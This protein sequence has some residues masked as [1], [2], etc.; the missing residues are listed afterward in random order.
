VCI[1]S[2]GKRKINPP[3]PQ[4][5]IQRHSACVNHPNADQNDVTHKKGLANFIS[6]LQNPFYL[7]NHIYLLTLTPSGIFAVMLS[8]SQIK[9][10]LATDPALESLRRAGLLQLIGSAH[11][12]EYNIHLL[13]HILNV[14][15]DCM[16]YHDV[17]FNTSK[18]D[19]QAQMHEFERNMNSNFASSTPANISSNG[20]GILLSAA[21][22]QVQAPSIATTS[23]FASSGASVGL[24]PS[25]GPYIPSSDGKPTVELLSHL[26][27]LS[28]L[29]SARRHRFQEIENLVLRIQFDRDAIFNFLSQNE[30]I[31]REQLAVE[32]DYVRGLME[33]QLEQNTKMKNLSN[34]VEVLDSQLRQYKFM[35]TYSDF[36]GEELRYIRNM[37]GISLTVWRNLENNVVADYEHFLDIGSKGPYAPLNEV[38]HICLTIDKDPIIV[39][40]LICFYKERNAMSY[41]GIRFSDRQ[42]QEK[43]VHECMKELVGFAYPHHLPSL[44]TGLHVA[45]T[46]FAARNDIKIQ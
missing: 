46:S 10:K 7:L 6:A 18:R 3:L 35:A 4:K 16:E 24:A 31:I 14:V 26:D 36:A 30:A 45:I 13:E 8:L 5:V 33:L 15:V 44:S 1:G 20:H 28:S 32:R 9:T 39:S 21:S 27:R 19:L 2:S 34:T 11:Q 37:S 42:T 25:D 40:E 17:E 41:N 12:D 29:E 23:P 38:R 22:T 43:V